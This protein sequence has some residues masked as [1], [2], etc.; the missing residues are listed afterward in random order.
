MAKTVLLVNL[1]S[2]VQDIKLIK[3]FL[4]SYAFFKKEKTYAFLKHVL[5]EY[6]EATVIATSLAAEKM[7]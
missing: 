3:Y 7:A 2:P 1:L 6:K 4:K 5:G